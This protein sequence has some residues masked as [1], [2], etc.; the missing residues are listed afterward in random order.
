VGVVVEEDILKLL[1]ELDLE[2][3]QEQQIQ[4]L[5]QMVGALMVVMAVLM[6]VETLMGVAAAVL[7]K[8][9]FQHLQEMVEE[10]VMV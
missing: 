10:V 3:V 7:G 2:V 4:T 8:Q 1:V 6:V 9:E 5:L